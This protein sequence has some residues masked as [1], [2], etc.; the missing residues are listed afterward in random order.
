MKLS[1]CMMLISLVGL[2]LFGT[3]CAGQG[4]PAAPTSGDTAVEVPDQ[5]T[6]PIFEGTTIT[7]GNLSVVL[8]FDL[9]D[10]AACEEIPEA[11][12]PNNV[13]QETYPAYFR[14]TL[15]SYPISQHFF[16]PQIRIYPTARYQEI[17]PDVFNPRF[18]ELQ[19]LI[20]GGLPGDG[21]L[22]LL[23]EIHAMQEFIARYQIL[24]FL[25]GSGIRYLTMYSQAYLPVNNYE[26]IYTYQGLTA[27][28][29]WW[30]SVIMPLTYPGLPADNTTPPGGD[31]NTFIDNFPTYISDTTNQLNQAPGDSFLPV[32]GALDGMVASIQVNP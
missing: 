10:G 26:M 19:A 13:N 24:P 2:V 1:R 15:E 22:P 23:P 16:E 14:I 11:Y 8:P 28:G 32:I 5:T 17:L 20:A 18:T 30:V 31:W 9:A 21:S 29:Q 27:D 12:D 7:C 4:G 25:N 3:A 6:Q